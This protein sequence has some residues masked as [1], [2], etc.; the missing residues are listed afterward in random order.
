[1]TENFGLAK[2]HTLLGHLHNPSLEGT[3]EHP[4]MLQKKNV[5]PGIGWLEMCRRFSPSFV[6]IPDVGVNNGW[7]DPDIL[8]EVL[9]FRWVF[10]PWLQKKLDPYR[11]RVNNTAKRADR[12]KVLPHSVPND[13]YAHPRDYSG[14]DFKAY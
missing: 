2:G 12:N 10:I 11:E 6:D 8:I 7:Y 5:M 13:M 3:L 4:W 1:G 9:V 14:L